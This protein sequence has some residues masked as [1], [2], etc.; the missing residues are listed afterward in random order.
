MCWA[1]QFVGSSPLADIVPRNGVCS[2]PG[3]LRDELL[4]PEV[5]RLHAENY[6]AYVRRKMQAL[7]R[8]QGWDIGRDQTERL[9]RR[10]GVRGVEKSKSV[11]TTRSDKTATLPSDL[12]NRRFTAPARARCP[13]RTRLYSSR[14]SSFSLMV[15]R[16]R[17]CL[18]MVFTY[19]PPTVSGCLT[20]A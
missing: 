8:R 4:V 20:T 17:E 10:A 16:W 13:R 6:G 7:L 5:A 9:M 2:R 1:R 12:V 19:S 11:F 3:D 18:V 14:M 15:K